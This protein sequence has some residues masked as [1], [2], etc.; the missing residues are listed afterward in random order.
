MP[1]QFKTLF[2]KYVIGKFE[3]KF[4]ALLKKDSFHPEKPFF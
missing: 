3:K 1:L 2:F 4:P